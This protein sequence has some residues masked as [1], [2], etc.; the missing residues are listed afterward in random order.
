MYTVIC[1]SPNYY[2]SGYKELI[3]GVWF[4]FRNRRPVFVNTGVGGLVRC[5]GGI[6]TARC[7][8]RNSI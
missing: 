6:K 2:L 4:G 7:E 5:G 3:K 8:R 1:C